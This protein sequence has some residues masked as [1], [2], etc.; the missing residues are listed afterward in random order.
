MFFIVEK[1]VMISEKALIGGLFILKI[2][3]FLGKVV[4]YLAEELFCRKD[5]CFFIGKKEIP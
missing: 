5:G 4:Y 1:D 3:V 2:G